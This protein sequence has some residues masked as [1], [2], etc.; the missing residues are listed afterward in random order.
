[1]RSS[2]EAYAEYAVASAQMVARKPDRLGFIEAAS[3]PVVACTARQMVF[4]HG[5]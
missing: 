2:R 3:V 5:S 4:E 1:M